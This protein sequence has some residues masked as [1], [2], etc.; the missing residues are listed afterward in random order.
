MQPK[1][2][3]TK[4]MKFDEA[5]EKEDPYI[6]FYRIVDLD[7]ETFSEYSADESS[8]IKPPKGSREKYW[9]ESDNSS[10]V[11]H[12]DL[13][14]LSAVSQKSAVSGVA[15]N[16]MK[17][18]SES[19]DVL[20]QQQQQLT[21]KIQ[22]DHVSSDSEA[23]GKP[24]IKIDPN[25]ITEEEKFSKINSHFKHLGLGRTRSTATKRSNSQQPQDDEILPTD[26]RYIDISSMYYW[27]DVDAEGCLELPMDFR[28]KPSVKTIE[29]L[30]F[31]DSEPTTFLDKLNSRLSTLKK[32]TTSSTIATIN[33][34][35][36]SSNEG[37]ADGNDDSV[38]IT[39]GDSLP[40][41]ACTPKALFGK[42]QHVS[43]T[44]GRKSLSLL[45]PSMSRKSQKSPAN[46]TASND[47][48]NSTPAGSGVNNNSS[49]AST[50]SKAKSA[51]GFLKSKRSKNTLASIE[52]SPNLTTPNSHSNNNTEPHNTSRSRSPPKST[53]SSHGLGLGLGR[54]HSLLRHG[55]LKM[56][57]RGRHLS[58]NKNVGIETGHDNG[59][60]RSHADSAATYASI[61]TRSTA[62]SHATSFT[63]NTN[64]TFTSAA[65]HA[66]KHSACH[67]NTG[68]TQSL[69]TST[70]DPHHTITSFTV[71][72]SPYS[73]SAN[74]SNTNQ[75]NPFP[76]P[77]PFPTPT[78]PPS[79]YL[80]EQKQQK[81]KQSS[82]SSPSRRNPF[83]ASNSESP[84]SAAR[85]LRPQSQ[86]FLSSPSHVAQGNVPQRPQSAIFTTTSNPRP[87][88]SSTP[89]FHPTK[90][91][92]KSSITV[93]GGNGGT[94]DPSSSD[95]A[96]TAAVFAASNTAS[97]SVGGLGGQKK[98]HK[99][100]NMFKKIF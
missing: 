87:N 46:S 86:I 66:T 68:V 52:G 29:E 99:F 32:T 1:F 81:F 67:T 62:V 76:G 75:D 33:D 6:L 48:G 8:T 27:Y 25:S 51:N 37:D 23:S 70:L 58:K 96:M 24:A 56:S 74:G 100:K 13:R 84:R 15:P 11:S 90:A 16:Q 63:Q 92:T 31:S 20:S 21:I 36:E 98:K 80:P 30:Q 42:E 44:P 54:H 14:K 94:G 49:T 2:D 69:P 40:T 91:Q 55:T 28:S 9:S 53:S 26:P 61:S 5:M 89:F 10:Q 85:P 82:F 77:S 73:S 71:I 95:P 35:P 18:G 57:R 72:P 12:Y 79:E 50:P 17:K 41:G 34:L 38:N 60:V 4:E 43:S 93:G 59:V 83:A 7:E 47:N 65:T 78:P 39:N 64:D 19:S 3:K 22:N 88:S 97:A 45:S